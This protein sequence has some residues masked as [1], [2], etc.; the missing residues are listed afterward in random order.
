MNCGGTSGV[1][2]SACEAATV[3]VRRSPVCPRSM[4]PPM[5][6]RVGPEVHAPPVTARVGPE[7]RVPQPS[8]KVGVCQGADDE[9]PRHTQTRRCRSRAAPPG[10]GR[11]RHGARPAARRPVR[12]HAGLF[13]QVRRKG[14]LRPERAAGYAHDNAKLEAFAAFYNDLMLAPSGLSKLER[15]MIAV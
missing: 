14:R 1:A 4:R 2:P 11:P 13:R 7:V 10:C 6:A 12:S 3:S 5:A 8:S 15:E 9:Q